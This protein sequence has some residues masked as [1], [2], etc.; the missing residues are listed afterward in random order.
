MTFEPWKTYANPAYLGNTIPVFEP[1]CKDCW[2]W[3]PKITTDDRGNFNGIVL[4]A[5]IGGMCNDFSC[6]TSAVSE[7]E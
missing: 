7:T 1:P 5:K 6:F 4:C 2:Y 3:R